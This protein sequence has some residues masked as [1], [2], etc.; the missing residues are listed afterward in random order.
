MAMRRTAVRGTRPLASAAERLPRLIVPLLLLLALTAVP[1]SASP[2]IAGVRVAGVGS[3]SFTITLNSLGAGWKYRLYA[4]TTKADL[5]YA[6]LSTAPHRSALSSVPRLGLDH[7][8]YTSSPYWY[9]LQA[10]KGPSHHTSAIL[11][12]G[13]RPPKPSSLRA[14]RVERGAIS[15]SW[16]GVASGFTVQQAADAHFTKGVRTYSVRG[17]GHQ[18]TPYGLA[19]GSAY[20]FRVRS[21]NGRTVS[22]YSPPVSATAAGNVQA[23]RAM[24]FNILTLDDDGKRAADAETIAPWSQRRLAAAQAIEAEAPDVVAV[25]EGAAWVGA[26]RGP[27]QVDSLVSALG[28]RY[29][30]AVTEIAPDHPYYFRTGN[31]VLY[32][33]ST[34]APVGIGGHWDLG[35]MPGGG[36]RW[37]AYQVLRNRAT[38]T[39]F[40]F[41][42]THLY[43]M[44][45]ATGDTVRRNET[46]SLLEQ[47][48]TYAA[49][50]GRL[51]VVYAGDFNSHAAHP[52]DG[53]AVAMQAAGGADAQ[54]VAQLRHFQQYNSANQYHRIPPAAGLALDH[55]YTSPGVGVTAWRQVLR[56]S[57]GRF[58]GV[59][60]S[61]HNPVVADL[62]LPR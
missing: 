22:G 46:R 2:R 33:T 56:L 62:L 48:R 51:P 42:S 38:G 9:R 34:W 60:P 11:S 36:Q 37:A 44:G 57:A 23:L 14:T 18:L 61:D 1:A 59:I 54:H 15:L 30:Q 7:L 53:P 47:A 49:N 28:G 52:L 17:G 40:L 6:H 20:W 39:Q 58:V 5:Y 21:V 55:L 12:L 10:V 41:I 24:T 4:S 13:L 25:Q 3:S 26:K 31:Y 16:S 35:T 32:R 27:R 43:V 50:H 19:R 29:S 8:S 45:G